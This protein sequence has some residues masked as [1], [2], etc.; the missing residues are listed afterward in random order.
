MGGDCA[1][2][3]EC[4]RAY[5]L[6]GHTSQFVGASCP[7]AESVA[8]LAHLLVSFERD[9]HGDMMKT[10]VRPIALLHMPF[11]PELRLLSGGPGGNL[12][13]SV[14]SAWCST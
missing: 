10:W 9:W 11:S 12:P 4:E 1:A 14:G 3:P 13:R 2:L 7:V 8:R 5:R 6:M